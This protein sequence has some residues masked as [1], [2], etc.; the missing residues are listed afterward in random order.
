MLSRKCSKGLWLSQESFLGA[1]ALAT[2]LICLIT[3]KSGNI[4][5][6]EVGVRLKQ[7]I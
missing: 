6:V 4:Q 1:Q 5:I 7:R 2:E 3:Q